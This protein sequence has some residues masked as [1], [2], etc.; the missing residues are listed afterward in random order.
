MIQEGD[1]QHLEISYEGDL[2]LT[3][4]PNEN[5][6]N[7]GPKSTHAG[8]NQTTDLPLLQ[9]GGKGQ[10]PKLKLDESATMLSN[11]PKVKAADDSQNQIMHN[12]SIETLGTLH[13]QNQTLP[14]IN[15]DDILLP[16]EMVSN[17]HGDHGEGN[18]RLLLNQ[19]SVQQFSA[20]NLHLVESRRNF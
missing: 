11:L 2:G 5:S 9:G 19:N 18:S 6:L 14:N 4:L 20:S 3:S 1:D 15:T 16:D 8:S 17:H 13:E 12:E 10:I 7:I